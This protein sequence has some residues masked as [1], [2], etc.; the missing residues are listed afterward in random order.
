MPVLPGIS[1]RHVRRSVV[2]CR[3]IEPPALHAQ[4]SRRSMRKW[5]SRRGV[6]ALSAGPVRR[7]WS[8]WAGA[9]GGMGVTVAAAA[10]ALVLL[11]PTLTNPPPRNSWTR[12]SVR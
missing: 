11:S 8:F 5:R 2:T 6:P 9:L 4:V 3:T 1:S 7:A 10:L 12:T